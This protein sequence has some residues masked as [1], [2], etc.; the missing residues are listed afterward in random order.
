MLAEIVLLGVF[1]RNAPG[2]ILPGFGYWPE[3]KFKSN[4]MIAGRNRPASEA[5][6]Q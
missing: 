3:R 6:H 1:K 2:A 4:L 5:A